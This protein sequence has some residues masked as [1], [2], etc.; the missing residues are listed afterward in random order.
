MEHSNKIKPNYVNQTIAVHYETNLMARVCKWWK[1]QSGCRR[2]DCNLLHV[3]LACDDIQKGCAQEY[4]PCFGCKNVYD[5]RTC[6]E[7]HNT[8]H[9]KLFLCLNCDSLIQM[10]NEIL[11]PGWSLFDQQGNLRRDV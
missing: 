10:K 4:Y 7:E 11:Y 1:G 8:E 3:T 6:I 2:K 5:D 9:C